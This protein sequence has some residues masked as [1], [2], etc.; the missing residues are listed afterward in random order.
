MRIDRLL[1][2]SSALQL[3]Q[4]IIDETIITVHL[5]ATQS[6]AACPLGADLSTRVHS[7][8]TR[9]LADLPWAGLAVRLQVHLRKFFCVNAACQR[10]IFAERV[11]AIAI[12]AARR[13]IRLSAELR[14]IGLAHGGEAGART[15][16]RLGIP[17]SPD[18]VLRLIRRASMAPPPTPRVL[19]VDDWSWRKG[20]TYGTLLV[21]LEQH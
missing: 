10:A 1:P 18:T 9:T 3:D 21:D 2:G 11:P 16:Q 19:G 5:S 15:L 12:P 4:I 7:R 17:A 14:H 6:T 13:T 8:Y 20:R